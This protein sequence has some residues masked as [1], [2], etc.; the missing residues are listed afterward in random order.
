MPAQNSRLVAT[1]INDE[2]IVVSRQYVSE[3]K[4]KLGV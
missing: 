1:L 2:K 4:K 3:I